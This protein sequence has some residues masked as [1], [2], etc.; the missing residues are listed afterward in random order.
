MI[1]QAQDGD[2]LLVDSGRSLRDDLGVGGRN[3]VGIDEL[4]QAGQIAFELLADLG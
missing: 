4:G 2:H 1:P 3:Q